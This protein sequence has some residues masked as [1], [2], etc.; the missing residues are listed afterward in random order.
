MSKEVDQKIVEMQFNNAEFE[1][2]IAQSLVSLSK[3]KEATKIDEGGKGLEKLAAS[4]KSI[5][6]SSISQ[7]I[8]ELN[9]R[10]SGLGIVGMSVLQRITN[11]AIDMGHQL[12]NAI[13]M[14]PRDGWKEYELNANS[15]QTILNSAKGADGLPVTLEQVNKKLAEL[16]E[17]SD[18]TIY[19]FSD[20][21]NNIGKFTNAGVDLDSAV[22]AIQGVANAAALA[23][24]D[25][26][27]ASRAMYNFG[28][29]LGSGSVKLID[30]KSIQ[31]AHMDTVQ[32]KEELIKTAV[33]LGTVRKEGDK[34]VTTTANMQGRV[35]D[36]FDATQN[37]NESLAHQWMTSEVLIKTLG[38]YTDETTDLGKAAID[39]A[40]Q[41]TT[42]S[43]MI[44]TIKESMGSGW[45]TTWQ[46]VFGDFEEA[47]QLWTGIYKAVDNVIQKVSG[48]RNDFLQSWKDKGGRQDLIDGVKNIYETISYYVGLIS[49]AFKKAFPK[50][51]P[52]GLIKAGKAFKNLTEKIKPVTDATEKVKDQVTEVAKAVTDAADTA[53]ER[54]EKFNEVVQQIIRGDWG[55][56]Q[57]RIDRLHEAG[58]A[59]ENLQNAVNELLGCEKRYETT[60]SDNEAVGE[61]VNKTLEATNDK[62]EQQAVALKDTENQ[63]KDTNSV[64][65]NLA[66]ILLGVSSSVALVKK[67]FGAAWSTI[68]KGASVLDVL[69]NGFKFILR[70]FGTLG[71]KLYQFNTWIMSFSTFSNFVSHLRARFE[72]LAKSFSE[73]GI[74]LNNIRE[75]L[76]KLTSAFYNGKKKVKDYFASFGNG[77]KSINFNTIYDRLRDIVKIIGGGLLITLD[78][79]IK[80]IKN[81]YDGAKRIKDTLG[82][83][84][85]VQKIKGYFNDF[86]DSIKSYADKAKDANFYTNA[87]VPL[88]TSMY[89]AVKKLSDTFGP[90]FVDLFN[91]FVDG[92]TKLATNAS[93]ALIAFSEGGTMEKAAEIINNFKDAIDDFPGL[94][95][96]FYDSF[97]AG[98]LPSIDTLPETVQ[99]LFDSFGSLGDTI[100]SDI[101]T[102]FKNW[103]ENLNTSIK[104]LPQAK[105]LDPFWGFIDKFG[106]SFTFLKS[107][108]DNAKT[109]MQDLVGK[110]FGKL[111]TLDIKGG[112]FTALLGSIA[113]FV[114]RWS[115]VG[116]NASKALKA[117]SIFLLNGGKTASTAVKKYDAFLKIAAAIGII[118][119]SIW[120]LAQVPADRFEAVCKTLA[121]AFAALFGAVT[122]LSL[123]KIP[124]GK[125]KDLGIAFAGLGG[126][127]LMLAAAAKIFASMDIT[128]LV[129][130]GGAIVAFT[131]IIV[132]AAKQAKEVGVGAGMAFLGL[133]L[134]LLLLVP[135]IK[136]FAGMDVSTLGKGGLAVY[137]FINIIAK[138]AS[139]A[140]EASGS[141]GA[142]FGLAVALL[143][144]I[145][146]IKI[147]SEMD[148]KTLIKGGLAV[149][150]FIEI[151]ANAAK[152]ADGGAKGFF[153]MAIA[154]GVVA[155]AMYVLSGVPWATMLGAAKGMS[156]V[157]DSV[158][159]ALSKVGKMSFKD[160]MKAVFAMA[161]AIGAVAGVMYLLTKY[162]D[163][164][165]A[166]KGALGI[167]AILWAFSKLGP[168][169][170]ILSEIP[171][172]AG[173][174]AAGNAMVFFGAMTICLGALGEI[175]SWGNGSAGDAIVK[176][177]ETIGRVIR[178]FVESLITGAP[179]EASKDIVPL[180]DSLVNFAGTIKGFLDML[181]TVKPETV[182]CAKNLAL[183]ILAICA[184]DMIDAIT[185]WLRGKLDLNGFA[186]SLE[187]LISAIIKMNNDLS[188]VTLDTEKIGQVSECIKAMTDV[189][190]TIPKTGGFAQKLLGV[191]DLS[192]FA[193]E[194]H[195]FMARGFKNFLRSL[196]MLGDQ[197]NGGVII[198]IGI[199]K[200][201]TKSM[202]DLAN[203]IPKVSVLSVL[204]E[205]VADLPTFANNMAMFLK[206]GFTDFV[207]SL[208]GLGKVKL[209]TLRNSVIPATEDMIALSTKIKDSSSIIDFIFKQNDL[210]K[211]GTN[212]ASFGEGV[213]KFSES[214]KNVSLDQANSLTET[215]TKLAD[216]NA[217]DKIKDLYLASFG[218]CLSSL[219]LGLGEFVTNSLNAT[220][221]F[222]ATIISGVTD[223]HNLLLIIASTDY[224][225]VTNFSTALQTLATTSITAFVE[226]FPNHIAEA[227]A[228]IE[229]FVNSV[230]SAAMD[231]TSFV[232]AA[233]TAANAYSMEFYNHWDLA[234]IAGL[235]LAAQSSKGT[236]CAEAL[237]KFK[238]AALNCCDSYVL[239]FYHRWSLA[240][241]AGQ[242][243]AKHAADG[244]GSSEIL[245]KFKTAA[246]KAIANFVKP[247]NSKEPAYS[248]GSNMAGHAYS[249]AKSKN[250][251]FYDLGQ[252][253]ADGYKDGIASKADDIA[254]E[255][256]STVRQ[257][258]N[259]AKTEQDSNSPSKVFRGLG[260]DA[261][262]GYALGFADRVKYVVDSVKDTGYA[263]IQAMQDTICRIHDLADNNFDYQPTITP[264]IDLSQ[265]S[266]GIS[267]ANSLLSAVQMNGLA[268]AAA[269]SI[270]NEQNEALARSKAATQ[271]N[272]SKD[273]NSLIENTSKIISAVRQNRYAIIDGDEAFNYFDRRLGASY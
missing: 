180:G 36:A 228:A 266:N 75:L 65:D 92:L 67:G 104:E 201:V 22:T 198:K 260:H 85:V 35:S 122:I 188:G 121:V 258:I 270:A 51:E 28:Q 166:L 249:G 153:G 83:L 91:K 209:D 129:K 137:A 54:C 158:G 189:A 239:G 56:G 194:M 125:M 15:V 195:A 131:A 262:D 38:K 31:T 26:N 43:K 272:Y 150:V 81:V 154:V 243:L 6:L 236:G 147:L 90:V 241:V 19:S 72:D 136:L 61:K 106:E 186:D 253:A 113:L 84:E 269:A 44:D 29:A 42:F 167:A 88:L 246:E 230:G 119:G 244:A 144:L 59:Y 60:M 250:G 169:I 177:A 206:G 141:F 202:I 271:L 263:G 124:D 50:I 62:L 21:T 108:T 109:T 103:I 254:R 63:T 133:S 94:I 231:T 229:Q 251:D 7:G 159:E 47:K 204:I 32:F 193:G 182:D 102:S 9:S 116:K 168:A 98:K 156:M 145:P 8:E 132:K 24:A 76:G 178:N 1:Q 247:F 120:L 151:L 220:P 118:A 58:Y 2:K 130:G 55:N 214:I 155:A 210:S 11:A 13:T 53:T 23:G 173:A 25:A 185:G 18:K 176:G 267:T 235:R 207:T 240:K 196:D 170:K 128:E 68:A 146:S 140:G 27:D 77:L 257:A 211:F 172:A 95:T 37:W 30:W 212:L 71:R 225:G 34:Y 5:D 252:D 223:L 205:G 114:F 248:A 82:S 152:K 10:F 123:M 126:S 264:V 162:S 93:D 149:K 187:P 199:V 197:I 117:V 96:A 179:V 238:E 192:D 16:N 101:T 20:M 174:Q 46:I 222:F 242:R 217:S 3:L 208:N 57:E 87:L 142:F 259:A 219:G 112:I 148:A 163:G 17:Y 237:A 12:A 66:Y 115:K 261:M 175:S 33:E 200:N 245:A 73:A 161:L 218:Q 171:F 134:A 165:E 86:K 215:A 234:N 100:Q 181:M 41:V 190:K 273:L 221:E 160:S 69:K 139:R 48:A 164:T 135:S 143:F 40:T 127:L 80:V 227:Q 157:L 74:P 105:F 256:A 216:L 232:T 183:A 97:K 224:S 14:A 64:V 255:A 110:V 39:A 233:A 265:M 213:S 268:A 78:G 45:M 70:I 111:S 226:E 184:A 107:Y 203:A 49:E 4:A 79:L 191:Q 52:V 138:A 89:K 99:K